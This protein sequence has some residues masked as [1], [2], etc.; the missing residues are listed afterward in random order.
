MYQS[1]VRFS[2]ST[3]F[4]CVSLMIDFYELGRNI[5]LFN[6]SHNNYQLGVIMIISK[7]LKY[8]SKISYISYNEA[9]NF[10]PFGLSMSF[11]EFWKKTT[12][13]FLF[14][15]CFLHLFTFIYCAISSSFQN[16]NLREVV[17]MSCLDQYLQQYK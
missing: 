16:Q 7:L 3:I 14:V 6:H 12:K 13:N 4:I 2:T 9:I 17:L 15:F 10:K 5:T 8:T 11:Q 1:Q